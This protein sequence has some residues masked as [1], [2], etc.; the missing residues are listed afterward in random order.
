M[1]FTKRRIILMFAVAAVAGTIIILPYISSLTA[2]GLDR[3]SI[4]LLDVE[5]V[6]VSQEQKTGQIDV[7]FRLT[8]PTDKTVT[9]SKIEYDL[10]ADNTELGNSILS[11]EDV[12]PNGRPTIL[13]HR[14]INLTSLFQLPTSQPPIIFSKLANGS[15]DI[16]W[17]VRGIARIESAVTLHEKPFTDEL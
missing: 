14:S 15:S 13:P 7:V 5:P 4:E 8:N 12:P 9:T 17:K 11:Y 10:I 1:F 16:D 2:T 3:V 6:P